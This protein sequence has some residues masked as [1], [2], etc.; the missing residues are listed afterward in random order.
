MPFVPVFFYGL[1]TIFAESKSAIF[2]CFRASHLAVG[3][4]ILCGYSIT[5]DKIVCFAIT[6]VLK[7]PLQGT[8]AVVVHPVDG[9]QCL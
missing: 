3:C 6:C 5:I 4:E 1:R 7:E 9:I 8:K 2:R